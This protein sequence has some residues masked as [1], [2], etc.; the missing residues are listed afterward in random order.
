MDENISL[1]DLL[2]QHF[3]GKVV[4]KDLTKLL[5]EGANVPIYVLEYL[6]GMYCASLVIKSLLPT[7]TSH[8][9]LWKKSLLTCASVL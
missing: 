3:Q 9:S 1:D 8:Q 5:K 2:N 4:H 7:A 6:L